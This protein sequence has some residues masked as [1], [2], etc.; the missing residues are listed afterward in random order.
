[1]EEV[2]AHSKRNSAIQNPAEAVTRL[3]EAKPDGACAPLKSHP[4]EELAKQKC[5]TIINKAKESVIKSA[6]ERHRRGL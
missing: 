4:P 3:R 2:S 5:H 1:M 6:L